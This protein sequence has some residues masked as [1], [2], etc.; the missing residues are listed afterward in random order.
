M[1]GGPE[2]NTPEFK[3]QNEGGLAS[4]APAKTAAGSVPPEPGAASSQE[5]RKETLED[6]RIDTGTSKCSVPPGE[7]I[8]TKDQDRNTEKPP[9]AVEAEPVLGTKTEE[10]VDNFL[11]NF[12]NNVCLKTCDGQNKVAE[13]TVKAFEIGKNTVIVVNKHFS[14]RWLDTPEARLGAGALGLGAAIIIS[15]VIDSYEKGKIKSEAFN[16]FCDF[17]GLEKSQLGIKEP[18]GAT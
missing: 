3:K 2:N 18:G 1:M 12:S 7:E 16:K 5:D 14:L 4:D 8:K 6:F 15:R 13:G 9:K 10:W 17:M 11:L